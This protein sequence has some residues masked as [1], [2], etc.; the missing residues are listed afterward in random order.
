MRRLTTKIFV[1]KAVKIHGNSKFD[2]SKVNYIGS[3]TKVEIICNTNNHGSFLQT[4]TDHLH[5]NGCKKCKSSE[6]AKTTE[7]TA[8]KLQITITN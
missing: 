2:Y 8:L 7:Y 1:E 4:P 5:G 6:F 3:H